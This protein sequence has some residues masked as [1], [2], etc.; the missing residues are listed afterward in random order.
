[1]TLIEE[2]DFDSHVLS[3]EGNHED[4]RIFARAA[5]ALRKLEAALSTV[6]QKAPGYDWNADPE[7]LT[8]LAGEAF[9]L[10]QSNTKAEQSHG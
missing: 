3:D 8:L 4:A 1:M 6:M 5:G 9:A 10:V 7:S 2:L